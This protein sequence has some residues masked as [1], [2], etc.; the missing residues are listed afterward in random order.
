MFCASDQSEKVP[1]SEI[2][3]RAELF[4]VCFINGVVVAMHALVFF[5]IVRAAENGLCSYILL[6]GLA[7]EG[8]RVYLLIDHGEVSVKSGLVLPMAIS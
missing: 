3:S 4:V 6:F 7:L 2:Q 8:T 5:H 1:V